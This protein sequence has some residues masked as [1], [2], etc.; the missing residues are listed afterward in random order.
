MT[1]FPNLLSALA[2][3]FGSQIT[4]GPRV[5]RAIK[6]LK[7]IA[8]AEAKTTH[9]KPMQI[10]HLRA[11][12]KTQSRRRRRRGGKRF[13]RDRHWQGAVTQYRAALRVKEL[14]ALKVRDVRI[15]RFG[16]VITVRNAKN[17]AHAKSTVVPREDD[18]CAVRILERAMAGRRQS[19]RI[20]TFARDKYNAKLK[21]WAARSCGWEATSHSL[22]ARWTTDAFLRGVPLK[23][24]VSHGRWASE[25]SVK[26][27]NFPDED[28][29]MDQAVH[30][31]RL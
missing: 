15:T 12:Y 31:R 19:D 7:A 26:H 2:D 30:L 27:Y 17:H 6:G 5:L 23:Q 13:R 24:V 22:R 18:C 16:A 20:F 21:R 9:K 14:L 28:D 29:R 3:R 4:R 11:I 25:E 1:S 8:G 10:K